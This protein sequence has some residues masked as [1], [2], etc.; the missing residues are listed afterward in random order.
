[1]TKPKRPDSVG[2]HLAGIDVHDIDLGRLAYFRS[3]CQLRALL[4][5]AIEGIVVR[6]VGNNKTAAAAAA[7]VSPNQNISSC[8]GMPWL[9]WCFAHY[10]SRHCCIGF[11]SL[12]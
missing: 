1:M 7:A 8:R 11:S 9:L 6:A 5:A 3:E 4:A 2:A 12:P 10:S